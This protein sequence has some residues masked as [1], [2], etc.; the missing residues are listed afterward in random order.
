M[1]PSPP[2]TLVNLQSEVTAPFLAA[3]ADH[4]SRHAGLAVRF[5]DGGDW[6]TRRDAFLR[7]E[8]D[9]ALLCGLPY[10]L[11]AD[12]PHP[13]VA[14][15]AAP[16]MAAARY[17]DAPV[18][19][20]DVVVRH[21]APYRD[22]ADL[23][24]ATWAYNEPSSHS[25][26]CL[27]RYELARSGLPAPHFGRVVE[28]GSHMAS[29]A[30]L[31]DGAVDAS[32]ID[33]TVL[34]LACAADPSLEARLRVIQTWGPSA[35]PPLLASTRVPPATRRALTKALLAM[36]ESPDGRVALSTGLVS[37][38]APVTDGDYDAIRHMAAI[39]AGYPLSPA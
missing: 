30:L 17:A 7:G 23:A 2:L 39:A 21:D 38:F 35:M 9:L 1:T 10:A 25:G 27:T 22:V 34:E 3:V 31:L 14:L 32:A 29:L 24:G 11:E 8:V 16:V 13:R 33:S 36:H 26:Y 20:S 18:Y 37:R 12:R 28:S 6:M 5:D 15:L 4:L 19:F